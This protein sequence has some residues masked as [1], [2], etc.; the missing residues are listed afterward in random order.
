M[1]KKT[2]VT[3]KEVVTDKDT[4]TVTAPQTV[5]TPEM[6]ETEQKEVRIIERIIENKEIA[7]QD[8]FGKMSRQQIDLIKRTV[9]KG[10]SDDELRMFIQVCK[11]ANLNPFLKQV[12][13]IPR[14]DSKEGRE[15][16]AI[17]VSID[18]FRAIAEESGA[19][20]GNEDPVFTGEEI[21]Q[22]SAGK[23]S[24]AMKEIK[25][26]EKATVTVYKLV[27]GQRYAFSATAR[28]SEYYPGPKMGF[29][30][31][32]KPYLMIGKCAEALALRKAFPK[33]LS[34]MY[35]QEELDRSQNEGGALDPSIQAFTALKK[36]IEKSTSDDL[37]ELMRK[38]KDSDKYSKEQKV[39]FYD[40]VD[41]RLSTL[42]KEKSE[43]P[44]QVTHAKVENPPANGA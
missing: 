5:P 8:A 4:E 22:I 10:A 24:K 6:V 25:V 15:I 3:E 28:W 12:H 31:H 27:Q 34:G 13:L 26:P 11:G 19:Y 32:L 41:K 18:G 9:A 17:Q 20:A 1:P 2:T 44:K 21:I 36:V 30:W 14:W 39:Q 23:D 29:Q 16:R 43:T 37:R 38:M 42:D 35:A 33:L 7:P 40:M